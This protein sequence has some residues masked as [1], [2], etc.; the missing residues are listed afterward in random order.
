[1]KSKIQISV[2]EENKPCI[3]INTEITED[4]RDILVKRFTEM[5]EHQSSWCKIS[6]LNTQEWIIEPIEPKDLEE[7]SKLMSILV[8]DA[9]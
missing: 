1:M 8:G 2:T 5:L 7:N 3:K 9:N 6:F 4:V